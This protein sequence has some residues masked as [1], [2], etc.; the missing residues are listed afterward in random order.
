MHYLFLLFSVIVFTTL[1]FVNL[2][3]FNVILNLKRKTNLVTTIFI[4]GLYGI[5]MTIFYFTNYFPFSLQLFMFIF[6]LTY[7]YIAFPMILKKFNKRIVCVT[8]SFYIL[9][10]IFENAARYL[11]KITVKFTESLIASFMLIII[12]SLLL[13]FIK[14]KRFVLINTKCYFLS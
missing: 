1:E 3:Y 12:L 2:Q 4:L 7:R 5:N 9:P 14:K 8:F 13:K 6:G 11:V 10:F